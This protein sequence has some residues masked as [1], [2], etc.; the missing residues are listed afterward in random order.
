[1][2]KISQRDKILPTKELLLKMNTNRLLSVLKKARKEMI[3]W[4]NAHLNEDG[5]YVFHD[6]KDREEYLAK[7]K[8]LKERFDFIK[9]ILATREHIV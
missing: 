2:N 5:M 9:S 8:V 3:V 4:E 1:M 7:K 6:E